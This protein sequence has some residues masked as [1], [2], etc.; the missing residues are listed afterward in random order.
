MKNSKDTWSNAPKVHFQYK[1][2]PKWPG[3]IFYDTRINM[4]IQNDSNEGSV[5]EELKSQKQNPIRFTSVWHNVVS[6]LY[7]LQKRVTQSIREN[8][9]EI[10]IDKTTKK[11]TRNAI[12][13]PLHCM[14][15]TLWYHILPSCWYRSLY[16]NMSQSNLLCLPPTKLCKY[17]ECLKLQIF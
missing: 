2:W 16:L 3:Y 6:R 5:I 13:V 10:G 17:I 14:C 9:K 1:Q 12:K 7:F 15:N 4:Y 8:C 11:T